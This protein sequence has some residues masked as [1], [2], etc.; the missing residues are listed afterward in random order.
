MSLVRLWRDCGAD[1]ERKERP[2]RRRGGTGSGGVL[3]L[4]TQGASG[5]ISGER[6]HFHQVTAQHLGGAGRHPLSDQPLEGGTVDRL[7]AVRTSISD[8]GSDSVEVGHGLPSFFILRTTAFGM[9]NV[10]V[11]SSA[12]VIDWQIVTV[13]SSS[14]INQ[15]TVTIEHD[16]TVVASSRS[17]QLPGAMWVESSHS[18]STGR[19]FMAATAD[20][21][22]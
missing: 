22:R 15:P 14:A 4:T 9:A 5:A 12:S 21:R 18:I 3:G 7:V 17:I 10:P 20:A 8:K 19:G 11:Q 6:E 13:S 16:P 2:R 1:R